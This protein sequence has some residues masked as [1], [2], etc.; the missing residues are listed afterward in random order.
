MFLQLCGPISSLP[1][2]S[3][4]NFCWMCSSY[5]FRDETPPLSEVYCNKPWQRTDQTTRKR[6]LKN[7][8]LLDLSVAIVASP[9]LKMLKAQMRRRGFSRVWSPPRIHALFS[10]AGRGPHSLLT[11]ICH[12]PL[13]V[14]SF[15]S[16]VMTFILGKTSASYPTI[17]V[18]K[19]QL[20]FLL[21]DT[22]F[23]CSTERMP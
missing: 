15:L 17:R 10:V 19:P 14:S 9:S 12:W 8:R 23:L 2:I 6:L 5:P 3:L 18:S 7:D 1:L 21:R 4:Q 11:L 22:M 16:Q 13:P 20:R